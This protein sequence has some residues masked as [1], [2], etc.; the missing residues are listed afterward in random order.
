MRS[1]WR[2]VLAIGLLMSGMSA[3]R[4]QAVLINFEIIPGGQPYDGLD[5]SDQFV[6]TDGVRFSLAEG[7]S[8]ILINEGQTTGPIAFI[9]QAEHLANTVAPGTQIGSFFLAD[10]GILGP[11]HELVLNFTQPYA[12]IGGDIIDVDRSDAWSIDG[13]NSQGTLVDQ[14]ML[15]AASPGAGDGTAAP[16]LLSSGSNDIASV[17]L[18]YTGG[19]ADP[20]FAWDNF[21]FVRIPAAPLPPTVLTGGATLVLLW[22]RSIF[23]RVLARR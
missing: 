21:S 16:F 20:G 13:L 4:A 15:T 23:R 5:I 3:T 1:G 7:G 10:D 22:A 2:G 11:P 18:D 12:Q 17:T 14:Q 6:P 9:Y 19:G 8:P